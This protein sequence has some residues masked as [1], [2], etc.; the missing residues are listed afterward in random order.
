MRIYLFTLMRLGGLQ[1]ISQYKVQFFIENGALVEKSKAA[2]MDAF[3][4]IATYDNIYC[5]QEDF[6][7]LEYKDTHFASAGAGGSI[8]LGV[9]AGKED[10]YGEIK[11]PEELLTLAINKAIK[12]VPSC[13]GK[14]VVRK[15]IRDNRKYRGK[16]DD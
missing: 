4:I 2:E 13:G 10:K 9:L 14:A 11:K 7:V 3:F 12:Y 8:A 15:V 6:A 5:V 16:K 1:Q